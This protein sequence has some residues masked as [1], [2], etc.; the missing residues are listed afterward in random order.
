MNR[1]RFSKK[2][3]C[4]R[5][6]DINLLFQSNQ[7][8]VVYPLKLIYV[9][10]SSDVNCKILISVPRRLIRKAVI[11]NKIKRRI[12]ELCRINYPFINEYLNYHQKSI[13]LGIIYLSNQI[14]PY[15]KIEHSLQEA[16]QKMINRLNNL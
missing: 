10:V 14:L 12:R 7:Y 16:I 4:S 11:R 1:L 15:S 13:N 2:Y 5:Y 3:R 6:N 8:L 9:L